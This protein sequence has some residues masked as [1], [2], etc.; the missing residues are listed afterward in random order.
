MIA[1]IRSPNC[2]FTRLFYFKLKLKNHRYYHTL[3][4]FI[5]VIANH[6][7]Y[8]YSKSI[9]SLSLPIMLSSQ[10]VD[11]DQMKKRKEAQS[12]DIIKC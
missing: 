10:K 7:Y 1:L 2:S 9:L 12:V 3:T 8:A 6:Y 4:H 5:L 11:L